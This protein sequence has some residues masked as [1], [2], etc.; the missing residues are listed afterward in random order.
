M[1]PASWVMIA[2]GIA[3]FVIFGL[4]VLIKLIKKKDE[5]GSF[6]MT[7]LVVSAIA[8]LFI[9]M[10]V[11]YDKDINIK[12]TTKIT[13]YNELGE[14]IKVYEGKLNIKEST[15]DYVLFLDEKGTEYKIYVSGM[16]E[17]E[18]IKEVIA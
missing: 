5:P 1:N 12:E 14:Q 6:V 8:I 9:F 18:R 10:G 16:I 13:I 7:M 17:I 3:I 2:I 15:K 11:K 4:G